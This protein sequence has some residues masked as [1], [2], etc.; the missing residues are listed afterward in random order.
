[1]VLN[2]ADDE[3]GLSVLSLDWVVLPVGLEPVGRTVASLAMLGA[4]S[5]WAW[6]RAASRTTRRITF[7]ENYNKLK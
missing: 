2:D 5:T 6:M 3:G 1:M 7:I 4:E